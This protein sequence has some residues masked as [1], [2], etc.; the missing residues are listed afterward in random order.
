MGPCLTRCLAAPRRQ[1]DSPHFGEERV[2]ESGTRGE[3]TRVARR[4]AVVEEDRAVMRG[5]APARLVQNEIGGGEI[6]VVL[7]VERE[8]R[9]RLAA[10]DERDA[11]SD[12]IAVGYL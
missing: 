8:R 7:A 1:L 5:H 12:G 10:G 9:I 11:V 3:E 2:V 4:G 6:P